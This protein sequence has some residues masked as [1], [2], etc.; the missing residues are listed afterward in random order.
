MPETHFFV[1]KNT[2]FSLKKIISNL[3]AKQFMGDKTITLEKLIEEILDDCIYERN[4]KKKKGP[5]RISERS[6]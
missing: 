6:S 1:G 5:H 4:R 2:K 3:K